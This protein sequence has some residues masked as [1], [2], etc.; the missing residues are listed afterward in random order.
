MSLDQLV[1]VTI[2]AGAAGITA[3]SFGTTLIAGATSGWNGNGNAGDLIRFYTS[4]TAVAADFLSTT[5]EYQAAQAAFSAT[6]RPPQIAIGKCPAIVQ[7]VTTLAFGTALVTGNTVNVSINGVAMAPITYATSNAA[8][9]TAIATAIAAMTGVASATSDGT[10][11]ITI[12]GGTGVALTVSG[13][14]VTGGAGQATTTITATTAPVVWSTGLAAIRLV[15]AAWYGLVI[16]DRNDGSNLDVMAWAE[17]NNAVFFAAVS[18]SAAALTN[19]TTDVMSLAKGKAY[20][21]SVMLYHATASEHPGAAWLAEMLSYPAGSANWMYKQLPGITVDALTETQRGNVLGKFG[22]VYTTLNGTAMTEKGITPS[23]QYADIT[24]GL[25]WI[26]ANLQTDVLN[27]QMSAPK[28]PY[29]DDG[30]MVLLGLLKGRIKK[31]QDAGIVA[32][33]PAVQYQIPTAASQSPTDRGNRNFPG[34][35][36]TGT[37]QGAI[38]SVSFSL[39]L[40]P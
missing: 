10:S 21:R 3:P 5:P 13:A 28:I 38:D 7:G 16:C 33:V 14:T 20:K 31:A 19:V 4:L 30:A 37:L 18:A 11:T 1:S 23:G 24:V 32:T 6:P 39:T 2:S 15:S 25:D 8:T 27:A 22:N 36:A 29:T 40:T 34:I 17:A 35:V 9:L 26:R 12:T